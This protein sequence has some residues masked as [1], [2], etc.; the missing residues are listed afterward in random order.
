MINLQLCR[1]T[2]V[3]A[4][5]FRPKGSDRK[6]CYRKYA[7]VSL[8]GKTQACPKLCTKGVDVNVDRYNLTGSPVWL[9]TL[10]LT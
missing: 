1:T 7:A 3:A 2:P 8:L 10:L 4:E 5:Q 6:Q 9:Q